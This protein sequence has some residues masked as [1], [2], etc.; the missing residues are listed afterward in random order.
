M[1]LASEIIDVTPDPSLMPKLGQTGYNI[2][3]AIAELIDNAIDARFD[4]R[5]LRVTVKIGKR[6]VLVPAV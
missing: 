3:Q 1:T 2:P 6:V 5:P 4:D